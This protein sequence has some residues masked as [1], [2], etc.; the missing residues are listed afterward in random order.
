MLKTLIAALAVVAA[1]LPAHADP[2]GTWQREDGSS[3][4]RIAPCGQ[5][6]CGSLTWMRTPRS[7]TQNPNEAQRSRPLVGTRI[8]YEMRANGANRW[9]G[10]A[11]NPEDGR[12]Y[13]GNMTLSG[14]RL[15]TQGCV[16]G[17]MICRSVNWTR[18]N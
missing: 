4:I 13:A 2:S 5:A 18:L 16:M 15:T 8:F 7:D 12:T 11:Y 9:S 17:G 3:R 10:Q 6:F 14:N 1:A